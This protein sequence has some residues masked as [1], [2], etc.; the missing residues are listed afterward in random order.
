MFSTITIYTV[1]GSRILKK[2]SELR[3]VSRN[4]H[5]PSAMRNIDPFAR[6]I[7]VTTQIKCEVQS[8]DTNSRC[9]SP[10]ADADSIGSFSST[11]ML[12]E[13]YEV[14]DLNEETRVAVPPIRTPK[15][16]LEDVEAQHIPHEN[17]QRCN[18][19]RATVIATNTVPL[20]RIG[21]PTTLSSSR[22][23]I[24]R[25]AEGHAAAI[26]S[27]Q[28]RVPYVRRDVRCLAT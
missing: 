17:R 27:F 9:V 7:V 2:R 19:Y 13:A 21:V 25:T 22:P 11:R 5:Q 14:D 28:G 15:V 12:S 1:T 6:N 10:E 16:R 4:S 26:A 8:H 23:A 3:S 24:K 20:E 18:G